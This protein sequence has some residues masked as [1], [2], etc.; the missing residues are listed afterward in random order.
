M[1]YPA[2]W[3]EWRRQAGDRFSSSSP[4]CLKDDELLFACF[5]RLHYD[6]METL[7]Q[8]TRQA[9]TM[10]MSIKFKVSVVQRARE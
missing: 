1:N 5:L 10:E 8:E 2:V 4:S 9:A 7:L 3:R 6:A